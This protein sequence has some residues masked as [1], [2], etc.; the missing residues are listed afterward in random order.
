MT[1]QEQ[2]DVFSKNLNALLLKNNNTQLEVAE[3]IDVSPQT[4]NTWC[5]G[6]ALPR[7]G[8]VQKLADYF[9]VN[10]SELIDPPSED[11]SQSNQQLSD[12]QQKIL[13]AY[14]KLPDSKKIA[15]YEF[16]KSLIE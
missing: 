1:D 16:V 8:K 15:L 3:A 10:K 4:F 13:E 5:K 11:G 6:K 14:D 7:M 9:G 2:R 12:L